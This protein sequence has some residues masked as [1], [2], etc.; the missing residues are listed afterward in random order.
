[1]N[2]IKYYR[3]YYGMSQRQLALYTKISH[4]EMAY[5]ES[6][7]HVPSVYIA[8]RLA[9]VLKVTVEKLFVE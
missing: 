7:T 1:M 3:E 2:H 8:I 4:A 6:G 5:I 9:R